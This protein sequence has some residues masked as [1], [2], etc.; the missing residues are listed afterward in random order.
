MTLD[1]KELINYDHI[2]KYNL[3]EHHVNI[4]CR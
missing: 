1:K 3:C 4:K 2:E